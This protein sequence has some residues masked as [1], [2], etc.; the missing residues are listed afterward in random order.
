MSSLV[1]IASLFGQQMQKLARYSLINEVTIK[2]AFEREIRIL[3]TWRLELPNWFENNNK[4]AATV[5]PIIVIDVQ[6][7]HLRQMSR[8][9]TLI[10]KE[11]IKVCDAREGKKLAQM[12]E[13]R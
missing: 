12:K 6:Y 11:N 9:L 13:L 7:V 2:R 10:T 1:I 8:L 3:F 5:C 4:C